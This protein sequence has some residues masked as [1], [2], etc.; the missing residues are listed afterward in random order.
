MDAASIIQL[1][2]IIILIVVIVVGNG[3][4]VICICITHAL[5]NPAS[6][7]VLSLAVA[8]LLVGI[9]LLPFSVLAVINQDWTIG[10]YSHNL[11]Y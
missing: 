8:D 5:H 9:W 6:Y 10:E 4:M 2:I 1:V 3:T 11:F 7:I